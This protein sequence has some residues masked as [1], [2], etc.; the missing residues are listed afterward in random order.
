[1]AKKSTS[2]RE[3]GVSI[4]ANALKMGDGDTAEGIITAVENVTGGRFDNERTR[5][6]LTTDDG[7]LNV[8]YMPD[9]WAAIFARWGGAYAWI[10]RKG[11]GLATRWDVKLEKGAKPAAT[12]L[13]IETVAMEAPKGRGAKRRDAQKATRKR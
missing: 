7:E 10:T 6:T 8:V 4:S 2:K 3:M 12:P 1:M 11:T 9:R 13:T 5:V